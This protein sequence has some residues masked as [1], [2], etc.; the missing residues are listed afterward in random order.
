MMQEDNDIVAELVAKFPFLEGKIRV[1]RDRR[2]FAEAPAEHAGEVF[3]YL[4]E[5]MKFHSLPAITG[6]DLGAN[7]A[8]MYHLA[9]M[10]GVN[11]NLTVAVPRENPVLQTVIG[12]FPA[13]ECY[14]RELI[15]LL[16]MR[17][18]GLPPGPRYP[19]PEGWPEG[20]YPL[21]KDWNAKMLDGATPSG[22]V[23]KSFF[24]E[25]DETPVLGKERK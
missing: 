6:L 16:G 17:V 2:I 1:T 5:T 19:L 9:R 14:E 21:R 10:S 22:P 25:D 13:A 18:E 7:L 23:P 24:P 15:D 12:Y 4:Y 8:A 11:L 3:K 20:Q